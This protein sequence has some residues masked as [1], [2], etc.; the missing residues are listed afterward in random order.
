VTDE[1]SGENE[2]F[3]QHEFESGAYR[4][5]S[6][7]LNEALTLSKRRTDLKREVCAGIESG[8]PIPAEEVITHL[9]AQAEKLARGS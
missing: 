8:P 5:R 4:T 1:V 2:Q 6:E 9:R 7:L 3:I